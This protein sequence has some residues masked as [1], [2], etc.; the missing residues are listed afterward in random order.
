MHLN[1]CKNVT[2]YFHTSRQKQRNTLTKVNQNRFRST[3][4]PCNNGKH[5][6]ATFD[7]SIKKSPNA[8]LVI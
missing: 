2:I 4:I 7:Y 6:S 3:S 8:A 5:Q 1:Y